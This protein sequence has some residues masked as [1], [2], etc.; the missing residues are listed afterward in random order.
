[1]GGIPYYMNHIEQGLSVAQNIDKMFFNKKSEL[2]NEFE[3]LYASLFKNSENYIKVVEALSKKAKGLKRSEILKL[4]KLKSG[5]GITTVLKNLESCGFI[6]TYTSPSKK[7]RDILY[8]LL[9]AYTLFHFKYLTKASSSDEH[10]WTN[11]INTPTHNSWAGYA[12]EILTLQHI[13][14]IKHALGISGVQTSVYA[15]RSERSDPAV[16]IDLVLDRKDGMY[17]IC[18]IKFSD[19]QY[20]ITKNYEEN[21]RQKITSFR[22]ENVNNKAINLVMITTFGLKKNKYFGVAQREI[23]LKDL[24]KNS[25]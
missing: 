20:T 25:L 10:F 12:F 24:F 1:M 9:D 13:S 15:W 4:T 8:Q 14:E 6:R 16:Q 17:N 19:K 5:E 3:N 18:E 22:E 23:T 21:L 11:S 7:E 2:R